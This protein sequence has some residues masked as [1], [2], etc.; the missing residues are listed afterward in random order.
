M[1]DAARLLAMLEPVVRPG[2]LAGPAALRGGGQT[3][4]IEQRTFESLLDESR[5]A[6]TAEPM[7]AAG[8]RDKAVGNLLAALGQLGAVENAGARKVRLGPEA[9]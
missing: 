1:V 8:T 9:Q 2:G 7:Q 5:G 6:D 4:P 3:L